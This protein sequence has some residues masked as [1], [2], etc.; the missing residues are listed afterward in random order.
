[1][2]I[3]FYCS[4]ILHLYFQKYQSTTGWKFKN[5]IK[6]AFQQSLRNTALRIRRKEGTSPLLPLWGVCVCVC[7]YAYTPL[8]F[9]G[10]CCSSVLS[11]VFLILRSRLVKNKSR[12]IQWIITTTTTKKKLYYLKRNYLKFILKAIFTKD[13][14]R[15]EPS[16]K[17]NNQ[18]TWRATLMS[19]CGR[20]LSHSR[21]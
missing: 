19:A 1:M 14:E 21:G 8:S 6:S 17:R 7:V 2:L 18:E 16:S 10:G 20:S 5:I 11:R 13:S 12:A 9:G 15:A 3:W 4:V